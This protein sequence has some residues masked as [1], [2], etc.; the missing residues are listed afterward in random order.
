MADPG[1]NQIS[2]TVMLKLLNSAK[3]KKS[4][5]GI[6]SATTVSAKEFKKLETRLAKLEGKL[7]S[8]TNRWEKH[9]NVMKKSTESTKE[10]ANAISK[11]T[12]TLIRN[13]QTLKKLYTANM[14]GI[15]LGKHSKAVLDKLSTAYIKQHG[16]ML[17]LIPALQK[18]KNTREKERLT[19]EKAIKTAQKESLAQAKLRTHYMKTTTRIKLIET[20]YMKFYVLQKKGIILKD[21]E[22]HKMNLLSASY[23]KAGGSLKVLQAGYKTNQLQHWLGIMTKARWM[24]VNFTMGAMIVGVAVRALLKPLMELETE[25]RTVQKRTKMETDEI[26]ELRGEFIHL[27]RTMPQTATELAKIGGI[28]GQLGIRGAGNITEFVRVTAMMG[29]ATVLTTEEAGLALAKL[30]AAYDEPIEKAENMASVINELS[31]TTAANSKEIAAAMLKMATSAHQL[32]ITLDMSAAISATLVDMGMKAERAGTRMRGAFTK[33]ANASEK[34]AAF[35]GNGTLSSDIKKAIEEDAGGAFLKLI[36]T[37]AE[38][39]DKTKKIEDTTEIF[40]RVAGSAILG[41]AG[42]YLELKK[43]IVLKKGNLV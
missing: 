13:E 9:R 40:G 41:L 38:T 37:I 1:T 22:I 19:Q 33:M 24:L 7:T 16:S 30:S 17:K 12:S 5:Q 42:N 2:V 43:N 39:E 34:I 15:K 21:A 18:L 10:V 14:N 3:V 8:S 27:S 6:V 11:K 36:G 31:N 29:T 26:K 32:G 25:M 4:I 20:E 23:V 35:Y 28:A